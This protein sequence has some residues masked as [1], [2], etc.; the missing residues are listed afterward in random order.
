[1][2]SLFIVLLCTIDFFLNLR[3]VELSIYDALSPL[4]YLLLMP[5]SRQKPLKRGWLRRLVKIGVS[6]AATP[7]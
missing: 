4:G 6:V 7:S 1:M 2:L 3:C 5:K